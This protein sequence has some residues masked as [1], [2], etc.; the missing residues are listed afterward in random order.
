VLIENGMGVSA[1]ILMKAKDQGLTVAEVPVQTYYQGLD[2]STKNPLTHGLGVFSTIIKL[3][4]E[5]RPLIYLGIPGA[6]LLSIGALFG[7]W[8]L[9][10]Y[11]LEGRIVT[12]VALASI[13]FIMIGTFTLFTS[14]TLYSILRLT[15]KT[16]KR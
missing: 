2:T 11:A 1:E 9:Q 7:L 14:I 5:E 3:V 15:Q 16:T 12:N 8:T 4:V 6:V 10:L 13:T